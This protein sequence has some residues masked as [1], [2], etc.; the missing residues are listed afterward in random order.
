M[1]PR[2]HPIPSTG[3]NRAGRSFAALAEP[4]KLDA[5]DEQAMLAHV[6]RLSGLIHFFE[7]GDA[8]SGTWADVLRRDPLLILSALKED[9]AAQPDRPARIAVLARGVLAHRFSDPLPEQAQ[10]QPETVAPQYPPQA[11]PSP[12]QADVAIRALIEEEQAWQHTW[13]NNLEQAGLLFPLPP[14]AHLPKTWEKGN[15]TPQERAGLYA[16]AAVQLGLRRHSLLE[17]AEAALAGLLERP[18]GRLQPHTGLLLTFLRQYHH[19]QEGMNSLVPLHADHFYR[20]VMGFIP[21]KARADRALLLFQAEPGTASFILPAHTEVRSASEPPIVFRTEE[22]TPLNCACLPEVLALTPTDP[23][24]PWMRETHWS[25]CAKPAENSLWQPFSA[26]SQ[27]DAQKACFTLL[28]L[29]ALHLAGGNR[30]IE[31]RFTLTPDESMPDAVAALKDAWEEHGH[32]ATN[33]PELF[34]VACSAQD[35]WIA[36]DSTELT[37]IFPQE[38]IFKPNASPHEQPA[39]VVTEQSGSSLPETA[40][41]K[42][43]KDVAA[44]EG[45]PQE[46]SE[47]ASPGQPASEFSSSTANLSP[48][49]EL[50]LRLTLMAEQPGLCTPQADIHSLD[51]A[52][53]TLRLRPLPGLSRFW[54]VLHAFSLGNLHVAV[55]VNGASAFSC[56]ASGQIAP[57][58]PDIPVEIFGPLPVPGAALTLD[59]PELCDKTVHFMRLSWNWTA[60]ENFAVY[61]KAYEFAPLYLTPS[62]KKNSSSAVW[63]TAGSP[64]ELHGSHI[65]SLNCPLPPDGQLRSYRWSLSDTGNQFGHA[66]YGT[67][68][69]KFTL[70][71]ASLFKRTWAWLTG[72]PRLHDLNPPFTP[73]WNDLCVDYEADAHYDLRV[74]HSL[75]AHAHPWPQFAPSAVEPP[76]LF[77]H[78]TQ[79]SLCLGLSELENPWESLPLSLY[80]RLQ[81]IAEPDG[82]P[83]ANAMS[84]QGARLLYDETAGLRQSGIMRLLLDEVNKDAIGTGEDVAPENVPLRYIRLNWGLRPD[85]AL[86]G[87]HAQA[88]WA[89]YTPEDQSGRQERPF[90]LPAGM[91]NEL[92]NLGVEHARQN[93]KNISVIQPYASSGGRP[94]GLARQGQKE[95]WQ[96]CAEELAHRGQAV[97]PRDYERMVLREFPEVLA[98]RC[99]P[100]CDAALDDKR[101]GSVAVVIF[102]PQEGARIVLPPETLDTKNTVSCG[103]VLDPA[104]PCYADPK[105]LHQIEEFLHERASPHVRIYVLQP[106]YENL[107]LRLKAGRDPAKDS[108][109]AAMDVRQ[110]LYRAVSPWAF[111]P[112]ETVLGRPLVRMDVLQAL[113]GLSWLEKIDDLVLTSPG[114]EKDFVIATHDQEDTESIIPPLNSASLFRLSDLDIHL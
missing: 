49:P 55:Q 75:L 70:M 104:L 10:Q 83:T 5:R 33:T 94:C 64:V 93:K 51:A 81:N 4:P 44:T 7:S 90:P 113:R 22:D 87:M 43:A 9:A 102:A 14:C 45:L 11:P 68:L 88:A 111:A 12:Q 48:L 26:V 112:C 106:H 41:E 82:A 109:E 46:S 78:Y 57:A 89:V 65:N 108:F 1:S 59:I 38:S 85:F 36:P 114:R 2:A 105:L 35:G 98:A 76:R 67:L 80:F 15:A 71:E 110:A 16:G 61:F 6:L 50:R 18:N 69:A 20:E 52:H 29:P 77:A 32:I 24:G 42:P 107:Y 79:H 27:K 8:P 72:K 91:L 34:Q 37:L 86:Q 84:V 56:F 92:G 74:E 47:A 13:V 103:F 62:Y 58:T 23:P 17:Q 25:N 63:Q 66:S 19:V 39:S 54:E 28:S 3:L 97:L 96:N 31:L 30:H 95:F 100:H 21:M 60:P 40:K 73:T 99:L 53:P 101:P